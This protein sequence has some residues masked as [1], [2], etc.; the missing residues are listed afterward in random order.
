MF[1]DELGGM[2]YT[3]TVKVIVV[4]HGIQIEWSKM[5]VGGGRGC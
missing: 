5:F 3:V 1:N 2:A 4:S